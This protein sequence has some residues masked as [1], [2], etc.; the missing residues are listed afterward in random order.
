MAS[1]IRGITVEIGG[2]TT[3]LEK[4]LQSVNKS[5]RDTQSQLKDVER[6]LKLDPSNTELLSQKQKLLAQSISDTKQKL[7]ALK[8]AQEQAKQQLDSG[9]L[10]KDKYDALQREIIETEQELE[11]LAKQA[12]EANTALNQISQTGKDLENIGN[13]VSGVGRSLTQNITVPIVAAGGAMLK[14]A[15][16]FEEAMSQVKA[17]TQATGDDFTQL[18]DKAID[19]GAKTKYSATDVANAM[20]EMAKSGW[21]AD[22]IMDGMAG[23]LDAAAASG[24]DLASVAEM[25]ADAVSGFGLEASDA[26]RVADI[27]AHAANAGT[28]DI[29]D[30]AESFKYVAPMA[31]SMGLSIE[32]VSTALTA[33]SK[34]GIKG[35]QA[36]TSLRR[37]LTNMVKPTKSVANAMD[38]LGINI[39]NSDGTFKSLDEIVGDLR[40][41]FAGLTD[42][43]KAYYA[44]TLAGANGQ[45]GLLA[46]LNLSEEEYAALSEEMKNCRGEAEETATVMQDNLKSKLEQLGGALESLALKLM[47][48]VIPMLKELTKTVTSVIEKFTQA[49]EST[50]KFILKIA[51]IAAAI[52][53]VLLIFGKLTTAVG[54][55]MQAFAGIGKHIATFISEAQLGVGAGGQFAAAIGGISAPVVAVTAVVALLAAAFKHLWDNN[56]EFRTKVTAIW[57]EVKA[58]FSEAAG[59][60]TETI[61]QLGFDFDGLGEAIEA[62]WDWLCN[63][64]EP[65]V[66]G[67][68]Q[69]IGQ[70]LEGTIDIVTG[71]VETIAGIIIGFKDGDWSTAIEG[72]KTIWNGIWE[73]LTAPVEAVIT[74]IDGYLQDFGTSWEEV[75]T[76][77]SEFFTT[78]WDSI[79]TY[80]TTKWTEIQTTLNTVWDGI[81]EKVVNV[82]NTIHTFVTSR[83]TA[84]KSSVTQTVDGVKTNI[85]NAWDT[86][87]EKVTTV[88]NTLESTISTAWGNI[89]ST[90]SS[91]VKN[92]RSSISSEFE[93]AKSTVTSVFETVASTISEKMNAAKE[94]V[95]SVVEAI[96]GFFNF[97]FT[98]PHI[99]LPHINYTLI[100]VPILG[101]IPDPTSLSID[102]Y[103]KAMKDGMILNNPTIFGMMNGHLLAG[104]EA[105]SETV[106]GTS[107]LL[108]MIQEAVNSAKKPI[109]F[110]DLVVNVTSYGTDATTIADEIGEALNR[111]LRM[112]GGW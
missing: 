44:A 75:W 106:V 14:T 69:N 78:T 1:R 88:I 39:T 87:N 105:G 53:P 42:E 54:Q 55:G 8:T 48:F 95:S 86:V 58:K 79:S 85:T 56:E 7:E 15:M 112:S 63:T 4:A 73:K 102:W 90:V 81:K 104:G 6:L 99:P 35:S 45:S 83:W 61:N 32:D 70:S 49:P 97:E 5:L 109:E 28:I 29:A 40:T 65:I 77:V 93:E 31:K 57:E 89:E 60:I 25:V 59:K 11:K 21:D 26:A 82:M 74:I 66:T 84:I 17:V 80:I 33:M 34:A 2:D 20:T 23:V 101:T 52:G 51:G 108:N 22:Q 46:L 36:G 24:E 68:I 13:K 37:M 12:G 10:G 62:A 103:A 27:L 110:G 92:V 41:S 30:L 47:D 67:V 9:D 71:I 111:K 107:S 18:R 96:K 38:E 3:G 43:E 72:L 64:L 94:T 50:Q 91:A 98:W 76:G 19:L 16:D 100:E